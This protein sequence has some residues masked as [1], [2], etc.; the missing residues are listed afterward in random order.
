MRDIIIGYR[1]GRWGKRESNPRY[2]EENAQPVEAWLDDT[3]ARAATGL[4][5][6][7]SREPRHSG[8]SGAS[9]CR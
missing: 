5:S 1:K 9:I 3:V 8:I 6:A 7:C 4:T 2:R